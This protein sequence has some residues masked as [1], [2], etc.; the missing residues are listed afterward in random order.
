MF[1]SFRLL[2]PYDCTHYATSSTPIRITRIAREVHSF[3]VR[4]ISLRADYKPGT[5]ARRCMAN[6]TQYNAEELCARKN[7]DEIAAIKM[8]P[9]TVLRDA[10]APAKLQGP[11]KGALPVPS[12]EEQAAVLKAAKILDV[13]LSKETEAAV[14][15]DPILRHRALSAAVA[16]EL[17]RKPSANPD[18]TTAAPDAER[19]RK[20]AE[21]IAVLRS[22]P[23]LRERM[24]RAEAVDKLLREFNSPR[25]KDIVP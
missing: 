7:T 1:V 6:L 8:P 20:V 2:N 14:G 19:S 17:I 5:R 24:D 9:V 10:L 11:D 13:K 3:A 12:A 22:V 18:G 16:M 23:E 4:M 21:A 25:P 15:N